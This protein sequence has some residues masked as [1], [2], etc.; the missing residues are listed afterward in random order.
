MCRFEDDAM[1]L[2]FLGW[3]ECSTPALLVESVPKETSKNEQPVSEHG[4][5]V[6]IRTKGSLPARTHISMFALRVT[7][8]SDDPRSSSFRFMNSLLNKI[9]FL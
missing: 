7:I 8:S 4:A 1:C 3:M 2:M 5:G 6:V 9:K